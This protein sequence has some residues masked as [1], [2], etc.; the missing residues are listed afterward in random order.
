MRK[1]LF[2]LMNFVCAGCAVQSVPNLRIAVTGD[3]QA[4]PFQQHWGMV[5]T[6]KAFRFLAPFK[7]DV[8]VQT[9][10][11][12]DRAYPEVYPINT[13]DTRDNPDC[14]VSVLQPAAVL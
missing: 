11:L 6:E 13:P 9:G 1:I 2:M 4:V 3:A 12:S 8:L 7:P 5:N 10:D 14:R